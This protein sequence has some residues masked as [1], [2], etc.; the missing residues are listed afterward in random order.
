VLE[1]SKQHALLR[2][3]G[4]MQKIVLRTTNGTITVRE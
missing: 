4:R 1:T 2:V 3:P